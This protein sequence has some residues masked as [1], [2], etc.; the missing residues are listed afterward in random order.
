MSKH[1]SNKLEQADFF[2]TSESEI[3]IL[4]VNYG[5]KP[6]NLLLLSKPIVCVIVA[7]VLAK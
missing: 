6:R 4:V 3:V 5:R 7:T 2:L 1:S